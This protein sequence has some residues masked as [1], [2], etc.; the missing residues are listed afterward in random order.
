MSILDLIQAETNIAFRKAGKQYNGPC[1]WCGD[2]GKGSKADRF[3]I[4]P[5]EGRYL[6]RRCDKKGDDIQFIREYKRIDYIEAC[7]YLKKGTN[8]I[9]HNHHNH[10][11][12]NNHHNHHNHEDPLIPPSS[13]WLESGWPFL[14]HCQGQLWGDAG[15]RALTWLQGRGLSDATIRSAGLGYNDHDHYTERTAWGLA[16]E[17]L[18]NGKPK[19]VWLPRGVVIPWL[20]DGELWGLRIRRPVGDP[21][22][23]LIPGGQAGALYNADQIAPGRPAVIVEG[24]LDALTICQAQHIAVATGS[25]H[26]ARRAKWIARLAA[27]AAVLVAYDNDD[28]GNQAATYWLE[29]LPNAKRWRPYWND[30]NQMQ[31]DGADVGAWIAAGVGI[32]DPGIDLTDYIGA[33]V[34]APTWGIDV[35]A[36]MDTTTPAAP[37][38]TAPGRWAAARDALALKA[39]LL[40]ARQGSPEKQWAAK[41][42]ISFLNSSNDDQSAARGALYEM[43]LPYAVRWELLTT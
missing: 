5:E 8:I 4:W 11:D 36:L 30:A 31:Q 37:Q 33:T 41:V 39:E 18:P 25:T 35:D 13:A 15:G 29:V 27:A 14:T 28:P 40:K 32:T 21:K 43:G 19:G 42:L 38:P 17:I 10:H 22:Y 12:N 6:C 1:P 26:G 34:D 20:V 2:D 7:E 23:Y 3:I 9:H 24:E 16:P